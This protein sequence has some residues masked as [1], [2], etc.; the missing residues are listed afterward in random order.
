MLTH[1]LRRLPTLIIALSFFLF[2][3]TSQAATPPKVNTIAQKGTVALTFDDGPSEIYTPQIL[4]ILK[5]YNV[6]A[7]FFVVGASARQHPELI[8]RIQAEG[9][10]INEHTMTHPMLTH[11]AQSQWYYEMVE[12]ANIIQN[13]IG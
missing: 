12:P 8:R 1:Y 6:K 10:A 5:K 11:L 7:T 13:I 4:D 3:S 2:C 9:H